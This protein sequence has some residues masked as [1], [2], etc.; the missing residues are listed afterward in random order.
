MALVKEKYPKIRF[1]ITTRAS[2]VSKK[3]ALLFHKAGITRCDLGMET[4]SQTELA[5][6][7]KDMRGEQLKRA[8]KYLAE[9]NIETKLFHITF[10]GKISIPT[11]EFLL[12]LS[13][14]EVPFLVQSAYLRSIP[15]PQSPP[16]F[17]EQDQKV[18]CKKSDSIEQIME[19]VLVNLAFRSTNTFLNEPCFQDNLREALIRGDDLRSFFDIP[20]PNNK[21]TLILN[22]EFEGRRYFFRHIRKAPFMRCFKVESA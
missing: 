5:S 6:V 3:I 21:M 12:E 13:T 8:V 19:W 18:F 11:I 20:Q 9:A 17:S 22:L 14:S 16:F 10:P 4:M 2:V 7:R 1:E 15:N